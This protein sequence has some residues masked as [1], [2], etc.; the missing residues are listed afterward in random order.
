MVAVHFPASSAGMAPSYRPTEISFIVRSCVAGPVSATV[1][2]LLGT[3]SPLGS[4]S[5]T[6][7]VSGAPAIGCGGS[8]YT[9]SVY[10][11]AETTRATAPGPEAVAPIGIVNTVEMSARSGSRTIV[12]IRQVPN[13]DVRLPV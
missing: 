9:T 5:T 8:T 12:W 6:L 3:G 10:G 7:S 2:V 4:T 11:G 1:S 13:I